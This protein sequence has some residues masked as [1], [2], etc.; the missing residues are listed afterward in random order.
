MKFYLNLLKIFFITI[1][2]ATVFRFILLVSNPS[3]FDYLYIVEDNTIFINIF[4]WLKHNAFYTI[5]SFLE[6]YTVFGAHLSGLSIVI[7][8]KL[9]NVNYFNIKFLAILQNSISI[10]F[11]FLVFNNLAKLADI[12]INFRLKCLIFFFLFFFALSDP[13]N[14]FFLFGQ[15]P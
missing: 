15:P 11:I 12:K 8:S 3:I 5:D 14:L 2:L 7:F 6:N 4:K 9:F 10:G 1:I 13:F